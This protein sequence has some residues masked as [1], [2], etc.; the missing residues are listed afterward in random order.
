VC[1]L[2][3]AG[4]MPRALADTPPD[5][6]FVVSG[7]VSS[8]AAL[9]EVPSAGMSFGGVGADLY[10]A[11][12]GVS[13]SYGQSTCSGGAANGRLTMNFDV[14]LDLTPQGLGNWYACNIKVDA[15]VKGC[16]QGYTMTWTS[17]GTA[18]IQSFGCPPFGR[19][20]YNTVSYG[21][22]SSCTPTGST[23]LSAE[24]SALSGTSSDALVSFT[25]SPCAGYSL[26]ASKTFAAEA[27]EDGLG[28]FGSNRVVVRVAGTLIVEIDLVTDGTCPT[29]LVAPC[30]DPDEWNKPPATMRKNNCLAYGANQKSDVGFA[31]PGASGLA[32]P[33][34]PNPYIE[35]D[36]TTVAPALICDGFQPSSPEGTCD[37]GYKVA[38][39]CGKARGLPFSQ[40][41]PKRDIADIH[42]YRVGPDGLWSHKPGEGDATNLDA[43]S[44]VWPMSKGK[45]ITDP[46]SANKGLT[47]SFEPAY[48]EF[49]GYFC[50]TPS[51]KVAPE[52]KAASPGHS[53]PASGAEPGRVTTAPNTIVASPLV[54]SGL[55]DTTFTFASTSDLD[56]I[57]A[58]LT[59]LAGGS[60]PG[61]GGELGYRGFM[62]Y[63][64]SVP[65]LGT[66]TVRVW[67]GVI[68]VDRDTTRS[69]MIDSKGLENWLV[70]RATQSASVGVPI[71]G[72][73]REIRF[74]QPMPNP[75]A[76]T[77]R[78]P[79]TLSRDANVDLRIF[80]LAGRMMR[81]LV[82]TDLRAGEYAIPWDGRDDLGQPLG[83][84]TY[85][86]R[87][88]VGGQAVGSRRMVFLRH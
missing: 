71:P 25:Q 12:A 4:A 43:G 18:E 9:G 39:F 52:Q 3:V 42:L 46:Q 79:F 33:G 54:F 22:A 74:G 2:T 86:C 85:F 49:I 59:G 37:C 45:E 80:D 32:C 48:D 40:V 62:L 66:E 82:S 69:F 24:S 65:A 55:E 67:S 6:V 26:A 14:K 51:T 63:V 8:G 17:S 34:Q 47:G 11:P 57:A 76:L 1:V 31:Y 30:Y 23:S 72:S 36:C 83:A 27:F 28:W 64:D 73:P 70:R 56:S 87:L 29:C 5:V 35:G 7:S 21:S 68:R 53:I 58:L 15:Y 44:W 13:S 16:S 61:W 88:S 19:A 20:S 38:V 78:I 10:V 75:F 81:R 50:V 60:D 41:D 77:T 84:G